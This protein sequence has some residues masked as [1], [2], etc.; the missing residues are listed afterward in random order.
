MEVEESDGDDV[1]IVDPTDVP[2]VSDISVGEPSILDALAED[3]AD[4]STP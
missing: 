2:A 1:A 4:P 3:P